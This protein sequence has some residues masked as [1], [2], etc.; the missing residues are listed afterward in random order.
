MILVN[1]F[2][3]GELI[4]KIG[5][6]NPKGVCLGLVTQWLISINRGVTGDEKTFWRDMAASLA[7]TPNSPL[8]GVGYARA[9]IEYQTAYVMSNTAEG[10]FAT[11]DYTKEQLAAGKLSFSS[12]KQILVRNASTFS[13]ITNYVLQEKGRY[14]ILILAD[15]K[16]SH[17]VGLY[18][19]YAV[20]GKSD[21]VAVFDPNIGKYDCSGATDIQNC[22]ENLP[23]RNYTY[24]LTEV[25]TS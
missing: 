14:S 13:T 23:Y 10:V 11:G 3:Q 25:Y 21:S 5:N 4:Q 9:A 6:T 7:T 19:T 18:R 20:I 2:N 17:A 22:L 24:F 8:L 15:N 16:T 1:P 12:A